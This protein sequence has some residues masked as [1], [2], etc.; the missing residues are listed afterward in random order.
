MTLSHKVDMSAVEMGGKVTGTFWAVAILLSAG[1][2]LAYIG[3]ATPVVTQS[4]LPGGPTIGFGAIAG[5]LGTTWVVTKYLSAR[6][7]RRMGR[8]ASSPEAR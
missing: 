1:I 2:V 7:W 3:N 6:A 4:R 8:S 5:L